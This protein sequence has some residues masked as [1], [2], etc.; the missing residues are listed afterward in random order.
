MRRLFLLLLLITF[1]TSNAQKTLKIGDWEDHLN[2]REAKAVTQSKKNIILSTG[3]ALIFL[4]KEELSKSYFTKI[5][6]LSQGLISNIKYDVFNDQLFVFYEDG[7]FDLINKDGDVEAINSIKQNKI[8]T[9]NKKVLDI[10]IVNDR[11]AYLATSFG[12]IQFDLK[13]RE[14]RS[15]TFTNVIV[16][17]VTSDS[18][19]V[20]AATSDGIYRID[21]SFPIKEDF[22]SWEFLGNKYDL[23]PLYTASNIEVFNNSIYAVIDEK[24]YKQGQNGKFQ[25]VNYN[26]PSN[27]RYEWMS[28]EGQHLLIG[29]KDNQFNSSAVAIDKVGNLLPASAGCINRTIYGIEDEKGRVWYADEYR[30]IR[31]TEKLNEGCKKIEYE[32]P[33]SYEANHI[34]VGSEK[35]YFS[36]AGA[37]ENYQ[38]TFSRNG[39][40]EL[41]KD[42]VKWKNYNEE[43]FPDINRKEYIGF[44]TVAPHPSKKNITY[45]GSF[46][47][48]L[49]E[50]NN[51]TNTFRYWAENEKNGVQKSAL[52]SIIGAPGQVRIAH[53]KFDAKENLWMANTGAPRPIVVFTK[54]GNWHSYDVPG[55]KLL[56]KMTIDDANNKWFATYGGGAEV[57]VFNDNNTPADPSDDKIK[58]LNST[59]SILS[60]QVNCIEVDLSGDVWVGTS[61]GPIVFECNPFNDKCIGSQRK[62]LQDSIPAFLLET[63]EIF[64][65]EVDGAN[66]K[67]FGTRNGIFVQSAD[68]ETQIFHFTESNSPLLKN[69][70]IDLDFDGENGLMYISS[71]GG[72]QS[73]KTDAISAG[74]VHNAEAFA[75]PNPVRPGYSGPIAIKGLARD[76]DVRITDMNGRLVFKTKANGGQ[77]IWDG[78]SYDGGR[79]DTGVY[80]VFSAYE[81]ELSR[82]ETLVTKIAIVR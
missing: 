55:N 28:A 46:L 65:I 14:F 70:I 22:S 40:Y 58:S 16:N 19:Y 64:A 71:E 35:I 23:P 56:S 18:K 75:F 6:G 42:T 30:M 62:V 45:A 25:L 32:S 43:Y 78:N 10:H 60:S 4:D 76:A 20:Y 50:I 2:Y 81:K 66:R 1:Y 47:N 9:G 15:T 59:N 82:K 57:V 26:R 48:G 52:Q 38:L 63:E 53:M 67:W 49:M 80:L 29:L 21:L 34:E 11:I 79:V 39:I 36:S 33:Y 51:Q 44:N 41:D 69:K 77:A 7:V 24:L 27:Y 5:D 13:R 74:N 68:A 73:Y 31:Y 54:E 12:V 8:L 37:T 3:R 17:A 72:I 61:Q